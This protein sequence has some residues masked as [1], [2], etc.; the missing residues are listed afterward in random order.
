MA[1]ELTNDENALEALMHE[2]ANKPRTRSPCAWATI[3][4]MEIC[5]SPTFNKE[6]GTFRAFRFVVN[7][8]SMKAADLWAAVR[9]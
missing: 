7:G 5:C 8:H 6:D 3:K 4:G 2:A 9:A 1:H